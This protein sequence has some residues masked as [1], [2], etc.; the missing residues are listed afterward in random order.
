MN[1][2][3]IQIM[4]ILI[5]WSCNPDEDVVIDGKYSEGVFVLNEG[6]FQNG[7]ATVTYFNEKE[8]QLVQDVFG[9]ENGGQALGNIGQSM[10]QVKGKIF[11][12][13]N[14]A[15]KIQ[16]VDANDFKLLGVITDVALPRYFATDGSKL[17]VSAWGADFN[18]GIVHEI[19]PI[20]LKIINTI[21]TGGSPETMTIVNKKLY[22]TISTVID[23][24]KKILIIDTNTNKVVSTLTGSDN[25]TSIAVDKNND[26]WVVCGGNTNFTDPT[27]STGGA[28]LKISSDQIT[29]TFPLSN[30]A[31][32]LVT[33]SSSEKL[34]FL[35]DGKV[36]VHNIADATFKNESI[37]DGFFYSIAYQNSTSSLYLTD[38]RDYQS[39]GEALIINP[40]TKEVRRFACGVIP[41]YV[42]FAN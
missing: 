4:A 14:N 32:G 19:D 1:K 25:P 35:M 29:S 33:N 15:A 22:V 5:I 8:N 12:A 40:D 31:K 30:G 24:S 13:I 2:Y 18:S 27:L 39:E 17:Y 7:T 11:I 37:Y 28:L 10:A 6:P 3:L 21:T 42:Y 41:G 38:P 36:M 20:T 34:Y 23:A 26:V 16:V 9:L